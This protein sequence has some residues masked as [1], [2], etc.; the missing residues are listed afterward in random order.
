MAETIGRYLCGEWPD[1]V[2]LEWS[3]E[4]RTG[5][6]FFDYNQNV[7]ESRSPSVFSPRRHPPARSP[8]R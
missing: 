6:M 3:V 4:R 1:D 8:C 5:K 2:T 7:E